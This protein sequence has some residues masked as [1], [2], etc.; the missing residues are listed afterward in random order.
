MSTRHPPQPA[1][2]GPAAKDILPTMQRILK[3]HR[4][5]RDKICAEIKPSNA[6]F[7]NA[8]SPLLE[9]ES[10]TSGEYSMIA[11]MS[12]VAADAESREASEAALKLAAEEE[13]TNYSRIDWFAIVDAVRN[14]N[15]TLTP[16]AQCYVDRLWQRSRQAGHGIPDERAAKQYVSS[17][18]SIKRMRR[19][20]IRNI[21]DSEDGIWIPAKELSGVPKTLVDRIVTKR[22]PDK[23]SVLVPFR[24]PEAKLYLQYVRNPSARKVYH[25]AMSRQYKDNV[26]LFRDVIAARHR[27]ASMLCYKNHAEFILESRMLSS[28]NKIHKFLDEVEDALRERGRAE[29]GA[30]IVL[31]EGH[32]RST[33]Y[34]DDDHNKMPLWDYEYYA[35]LKRESLKICE[36]QYS[37]YFP[38]ELVVAG[39]LRTVTECLGLRFAPLTAE[40]MVGTIWH[41]D[42]MGWAVWEDDVTIKNEEMFVG[43]LYMDLLSRENK[44]RGS[45][46]HSLQSPEGGS[47]LLTQDNIVALFHECGHALHN[48]LSRDTYSHF[49]GGSRATRQSSKVPG[50]LFENWCWMKK[51]LRDMNRHYAY[52]KPYCLERWLEEHPGRAAPPVRL[53]DDD[54]ERLV[55]SRKEGKMSWYLSQLAL[56]RF[57]MAVHG[58]RSLDECLK[59]DPA[60]L[61]YDL[62]E[63][64][65]FLSRPDPFNIGHPEV[66]FVELMNGSDA[67]LHTELS[68]HVAAINIYEGMF[69]EK[70]FNRGR[71]GKVSL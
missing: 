34:P 19:R 61:Y 24:E 69:A 13:A 12:E 35:R 46:S 8:I 42:V 52:V 71:L 30:L 37:E 49:H 15:E 2:K 25:V 10:Q 48:L 40:E 56:S 27:S 58:C 31:K 6:C 41:E 14:K 36:S 54:L 65:C 43:Y 55:S 62:M 67:G 32:L 9:V 68:A 44:A 45:Q 33:P 11:L 63:K 21:T 53:S 64:N 28:T 66:G 39:L 59:L 18:S 22:S 3:E 47:T 57:D 50:L 60:T 29:M 1:P 70:P 5:V 17:Q 7:D 4:K 16:E 23:K 20:Y 38:L 51:T 26:D